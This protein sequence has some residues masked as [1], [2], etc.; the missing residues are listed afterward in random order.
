MNI[1][2]PKP[3]AKPNKS[4]PISTLLQYQIKRLWESRS[5][6]MFLPIAPVYQSIR[7]N[8]MS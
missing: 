3:A 4:R 2:V 7:K 1:D 6:C 8:C 5:N